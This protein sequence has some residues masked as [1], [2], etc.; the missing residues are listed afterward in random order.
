MRIYVI[1]ISYTRL[2]PIINAKATNQV[3]RAR[4]AQ[5]IVWSD[6]NWCSCG[7]SQVKMSSGNE[8]S[9]RI[10]KK[11]ATYNFV[12]TKNSIKLHDA[13]LA[14]Y[15]LQICKTYTSRN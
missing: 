1:E 12:R 9:S 4:H 13:E 14:Y 2:C 7:N 6:V 15:D 3:P 11:Y 8:C 10:I 5:I